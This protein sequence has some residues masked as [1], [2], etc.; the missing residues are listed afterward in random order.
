MDFELPRDVKMLQGLVRKFVDQ[1]LLPI[2]MEV[3]RSED[4][5]DDVLRPLQEKVKAL[6]LWL[7][8]VPKEYGGTALGLLAQCVVQ[9]EIGRTKAIPFRINELF[10][11][12][13][14]PILLDNCNDD[15]K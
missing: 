8:D 3:N 14:S 10:G 12:I 13:V 4:L 15:Q 6:G 2:E 5:A 7:L 11:P 1:E 9:E